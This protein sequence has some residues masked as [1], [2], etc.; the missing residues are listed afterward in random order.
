MFGMLAPAGADCPDGT[1]F[2]PLVNGSEWTHANG[3]WTL[4]G[5]P[6]GYFL[7]NQQCEICPGGTYCMGSSIPAT[8]CGYS[9]YTLPG[10]TAAEECE[11]A[12]F[13]IVTATLPILRF[14]FSD[15]VGERFSDALASICGLDRGYVMISSVVGSSRTSVSCNI[16]T[17][18]AKKAAAL[19]EA[20]DSET[21]QIGMQMHGFSNCVLN[22]V[23]LTACRPGFALTESQTCQ[24]CPAGSY[25]AGGS[26][27]SLPCSAGYYAFPGSNSSSDCKAAVFVVVVVSLPI[28]QGNFTSFVAARFQNALATVAGVEPGSVFVDTDIQDRRASGSTIDVTAEIAVADPTTLKTVASRISPSALNACL[29]SQGLPE[30]SLQSVKTTGFDSTEYEGPPV[31]LIVGVGVG[32]LMVFALFVTLFLLRKAESK[33]EWEL[34]S[35]INHLRVQLRIT[36][37]DGYILG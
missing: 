6:P 24:I 20:L 11:P 9:L 2:V 28:A 23:Q 10:A 29:V 36:P 30:G 5:C 25:C 27:P 15:S 12:V 32:S 22:S 8:P 31:P 21:V 26:S 3:V 18:D 4:V 33:E 35:A 19:A 16:A 7:G 17:A 37:R 13:V 1:R 14:A 34:R